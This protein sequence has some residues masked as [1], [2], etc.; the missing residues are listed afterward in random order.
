MNVSNSVKAKVVSEVLAPTKRQRV[1]DGSS[2]HEEREA[3]LPIS[4][5]STVLQLDRYDSTGNEINRAGL[6]DE[7]ES[8]GEDTY[9]ISGKA[10]RQQQIRL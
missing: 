4:I 3:T 2:T 7:S 6:E 10:R 9:D 8:D 5:D 1:G